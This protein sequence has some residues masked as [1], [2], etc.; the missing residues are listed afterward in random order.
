MTDVFVSYSRSDSE[1]VSRLADD[2][3]HRGKDVWVDVD[4]IRDAEKFPEALRRAIEGSDAFVFVIS[5]DSVGSEF[6]DQEVAHASA[7]NKR[8][9][10]L[11]LRPAPDEQI[12]AEIRL[13][14]WIPVGE[15]TGVNRVIDAIETDLEW[16]RQHT[17][18][19]LRALQWEQAGRDRSVLLRG[20]ELAD[21]ERWLAAG[22]G[23]DPG[24]TA[25][26]QEYLLAAR[27]AASR[28]QRT[29]TVAVSGM[30]VV[31]VGLLVFALIS[32][33]KAV[34]AE[35]SA[36][37]QRLAAL[38]E[39]QLSI[40][41][42]RAV[43]LG[44]AA[45]RRD[46]T[47][48]PSGTMFA[49]RAALDAS[50]IR[51]RL[52]PAGE[53]IGCG[54]LY[55]QFDPAPG[56]NLVA[57]GLCDGKM[58]FLD[59]R[60]GR[61]ERVVTLGSPKESAGLL[62]YAGRR[63][64]LVG[65]VGD[66]LVALDPTTAALV[67]RGPVVP[68]L[69]GEQPDTNAPLLAAFGRAPLGRRGVFVVWNYRTGRA[70]WIHPPLPM[71]YLSGLS[72]AGPGTLALTFQG[73]A[74]GPGLALYDYIDRRVVATR[75]LGSAGAV[76]STDGR[77]L[78]VG[79][80]RAD[81]TG[82]VELVNAQTLAPERGFRPP[83]FSHGPPIGLAF[84]LDDRLLAYGFQDGSAGVLDVSTGAPV[85]TYAAA[86]REV[87]GVVISPDDRLVITAS[88][89]GTARAERIGGRA[90][91]TIDV[92]GSI[93]QLAVVPDGFLT[94]GNPGP[95]P[96]EGVVVEHYTD[97][98]RAVG[99]PLVMSHQTQQLDASLSR[100][101]TLATDV[102]APPGAQSAP[103]SEWSVPGRR[104]VRTITFPNGAGG[105][106]VIS[107]GGDLLLTGPGPPLGFNTPGR[108]PLVLID[109]RTGLRRT[110]PA[111]TG[112]PWP[113]YAF[114]RT[115]AAVAAGTYCG[116]VGVWNTV[117]GRRLGG[118]IH[119][120]GS[121]NSLAFSPDGHSLA[122]ASS[123]GTV[124]VARV[125][126][127]PT[128]RPLHAS[129][130][131]VQAVAY[132]PDGRYLATVGLART[133]H[134]YDARSLT[135]LRVIPLPDAPHGLAFTAD[136]QG[137]LTWDATGKVTLWDA[138]TYCEN[139]SALLRLARSRVTRSLTPAERKTYGVS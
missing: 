66:R 1:F 128:T 85:D 109:L 29:L 9:V 30:L 25:L 92:G 40:D 137:L 8:I 24:P 22:A 101:G 116:Q 93:P 55:P 113:A 10:P 136:S 46:A 12:P 122:I 15:D 48:G 21:A 28:R 114:S 81:G 62:S 104:I 87:T 111:P 64:I 127:T 49:L 106:P 19:T 132:S 70:I 91:R 110:L 14:N 63:A 95:R 98:G 130:Q 5:P 72:F 97:A 33:Q 38:S 61:L 129:T 31:A 86:T 94:I 13:R 67:R 100:D 45:V 71:A 35:S 43:L 89:D 52:P 57:E 23:K 60:N 79:L 126:L 138:C 26:E 124:Y 36:N 83:T 119:L 139:P 96:G 4:G 112:C 41:P 121:V 105:D 77:T 7:L 20:S 2:L 17:R 108:R 78:A 50:T 34:S 39:T 65:A 74:G 133:A 18:I 44:M 75:V 135:E 115:G 102:P 73:D 16:E 59:A 76:Q 90:L 54:A 120:P 42:E 88:A 134:V 131:S 68:E 51:Y 11:A 6:C 56:S 84:S 118:L 37:A 69:G 125:P 47:Y 58:R 107:P 99:S 27:Q 80:A 32:R 53:Q 3:K 123:N 82:T 103:M 117:S